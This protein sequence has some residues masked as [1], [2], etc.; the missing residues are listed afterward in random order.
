MSRMNILSTD[1]QGPEERTPNPY[2]KA[3]EV[4]SIMIVMV[5]DTGALVPAS[6]YLQPRPMSRGGLYNYSGIHDVDA[7][8]Y[9]SRERSKK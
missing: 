5:S 1:I 6:P 2:S 9:T 4:Y 3:F 8:I 7:G